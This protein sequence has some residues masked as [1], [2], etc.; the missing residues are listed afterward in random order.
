MIIINVISDTRIRIQIQHQHLFIK[1]DMQRYDDLNR[2]VLPW[3]MLSNKN[4]SDNRSIRNDGE[5]TVGPKAD[6]SLLKRKSKVGIAF[7]P[8]RL[9]CSSVITADSQFHGLSVT[10]NVILT[11]RHSVYN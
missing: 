3:E 9:Y 7:S 10:K 6:A 1:H 4:Q 5:S 2:V 8:F 11:C